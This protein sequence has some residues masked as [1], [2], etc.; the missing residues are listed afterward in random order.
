MN[1]TYICD[2]NNSSSDVGG[3]SENE[4]NVSSFQ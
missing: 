4:E 1:K 2:N 3:T